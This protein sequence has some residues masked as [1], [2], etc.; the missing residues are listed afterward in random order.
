[1]VALGC[2]NNPKSTNSSVVSTNL[3]LIRDSTILNENI[4]NRLESYIHKSKLTTSEIN[5]VKKFLNHSDG[6]T[7][8]Y[9]SEWFYKL[10]KENSSLFISLV[11]NEFKNEKVEIIYFLCHE[12]AL[13]DY[14]S[15]ETDSVV[16]KL[17]PNE[18]ELQKKLMDC[19]RKTK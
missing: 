13:R 19:I 17:V 12:I 7:L 4:Y 5:D 8:E 16:K 9:I 6:A 10:S 18:Y 1:M 11:S 14:S 2:T 15:N 3:P